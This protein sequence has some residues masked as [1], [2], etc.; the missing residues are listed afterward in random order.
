MTREELKDLCKEL[1]LDEKIGMVHGSILFQTAGVERLGIP[2]FLFSDGPMGCRLEYEAAEWMPVANNDD[3]TSYLPSNTALAST[4]SRALAHD[5]GHILGE[6]TRGRGKDMILAPGINIQRSPLGGRNFEYMSEDPYLSG[7]MA[8]SYVRGVQENDVSACL[9]HFALNNQET[10]RND[11]DVL[12]S[13]RA[14][15]ELY[16]PAFRAAIKEG[17]TWGVMG[18]Y[19]KFHGK[20]CSHHPFLLHDILRKEWGFDGI[21]V[22]DWGSIHD[23]VEGGNAAID[24]DMRTTSNFDDYPFGKPLKEA[25]KNGSVSAE[26]LDEKVMHI[27]TTMNQLH[28]LDGER[29]TGTYNALSSHS[30]L[31]TAAEESI[32]LLKNESHQLPLSKKKIRKLLVVGDNANRMHA[33]G[34]GSAEIKA[35]YE[36]SPLM[37]IKMELGGNC[38]VIYEPG[39]Y[40]YVIGNAWGHD[41]NAQGVGGNPL[42]HLSAAEETLKNKE[43]LS[44]ALE[45]ATDADA[46]IFIGG[47]SHDYDVEGAD[48]KDMKLPNNQ[49]H[50][51]KELLK[52][53]PDLIVALL[54]GSPVD[55]SAWVDDVKSLLF[56]SYNGMEGGRGFARILFGEANP[57]GKL[58][59]T[60][61]GA[62]EDSPAHKIGQFPGGDTVAYTEDIYVGYRYFDTFDVTPAF[63]FGHGLSYTE[64]QFGPVCLT[65][66]GVDC[67]I[68]GTNCSDKNERKGNAFI[69]SASVNVTNTGDTDGSATVLF[70]IRPVDS[71]IKRPA[72]ELRGFDKVFLL[73]GECKDVSVCF[74]A[75]SFSYYNEEK[76]C[77]V[78][79]PGT[80]EICAAFA[81]DDI[82]ST[83]SIKIDREYLIER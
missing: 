2:G 48:K 72:K 54:A 13:D 40:N 17:N 51:I 6:E 79:E 10:R 41:D 1:T 8:V 35:L 53:R 64:F 11:V 61:P 42:V 52:V 18:S 24:V 66:C 34:G 14:L 59:M 49:D 69:T 38:E 22:S 76:K 68:S 28:M 15:F 4:F 80:Y 58:P 43:Y 30:K 19:N 37:G 32:I 78:T 5:A 55:M 9:K 71:K 21:V 20:Y 23:S 70:F 31:L 74:D 46:V 82:R 44:R 27:L 77:Y 33:L 39:Y 60:L 75:Y 67:E 29:K 26:A 56:F 12:V 45:A 50:I 25:V 7:E 47:L 73:K 65:E 16:L 81:A 62:L 83:A 3:F 57:S 36:I 63:A